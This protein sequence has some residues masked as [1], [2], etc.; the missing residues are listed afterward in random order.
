MLV[1]FRVGLIDIFFLYVFT[2]ALPHSSGALH[3]TKG[4]RAASASP[5]MKGKIEE[6]NRKLKECYLLAIE[7][8]GR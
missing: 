2:Y 4:Q 7:S 8:G 3:I 1:L 6:A 5:R